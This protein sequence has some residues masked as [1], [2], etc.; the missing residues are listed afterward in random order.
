ML[1]VLLFHV[2]TALHFFLPS[3]IYS[4]KPM[5]ALFAQCDQMKAKQ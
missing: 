3:G 4:Q 1:E 2:K 5:E